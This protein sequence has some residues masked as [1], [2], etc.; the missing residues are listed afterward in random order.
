VRAAP[1][2]LGAPTTGGGSARPRGGG[3][4]IP[5]S[6]INLQQY[7]IAKN[8]EKT[9]GFAHVLAYKVLKTPFFAHKYLTKYTHE[10]FFEEYTN[11]EVHYLSHC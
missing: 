4:E 3:G 1:E 10:T 7:E 2:L 11:F 6:H 9:G 5:R 8:G